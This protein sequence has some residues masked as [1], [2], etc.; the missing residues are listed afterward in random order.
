MDHDDNEYE[1]VYDADYHDLVKEERERW[2]GCEV[3]GVEMNIR[4][5]RK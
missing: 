5:M 2:G 1:F 4:V 3:R